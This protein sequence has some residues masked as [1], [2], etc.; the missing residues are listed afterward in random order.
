M[1]SLGEAQQRVRAAADVLL[2][3]ENVPLLSS[4]GRFLAKDFHSDTP[5]PSSDRSA[6]D[7]FGV[8]AGAAGLA[9]GTTL[10]LVGEC[11]AG[12][13]FAGTVREGQALRIMTGAVVPESVDCVV[14]VENTSGFGGAEVTLHVDV[15]KGDNIRLLGSE[16]AMG[17]LLLAAGTRI[18][19]AEIG[20]LAV[21]G[22]DP[23]PVFRR[24]RVA[25]LATGDE[26]VEIDRVPATHQV[27]NSN[28]YAL[29]AQ[30]AEAGGEALLLGIARDQEAT[31]RAHLQEGL[32]AADVLLSIGGVSKGTHD[33]V[34]R[35]LRE[36]GVEEVF[37]GVALKPGKPVFFGRVAGDAPRFVFGLPG[38]PASCFTVFHLLVA[39]LLARICGARDPAADAAAAR[40]HV[41]GQPFRKNRRLQAIPARLVLGEDGALTAALQSG[42]P[43]GNPFG[44]LGADAYGLVPP[45]STPDTTPLVRV[46][47]FRP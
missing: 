18:H 30:V 36:L 5:W 40:V 16:V 37:H 12:H 21:L 22:I 33:L 1:I 42:K 39:P 19:A 9:A 43:S 17:Q 23:V 2:E 27:R 13:P 41:G 3:P 32:A 4:G 31:L 11:L 47:R 6:M 7:G 20:A 10:T 28:T 14:P 38:N 24:P 26:V 8:R 44:L 15:R 46:V 25:I 34:H 29:A 35:L 45:E